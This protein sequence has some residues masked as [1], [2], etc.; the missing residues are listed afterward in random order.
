MLMRAVTTEAFRT[1]AIETQ[2][3][4][5]CRET[6]PDNSI[7]KALGIVFSAPL[8]CS[9]SVDMVNAQELPLGF[10]AA[11]AAVTIMIIN[12][13][14]QLVGFAFRIGSLFQVALLAINCP[15][16][17]AEAARTFCQRHKTDTP[18]L[19]VDGSLAESSWGAR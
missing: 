3:L 7:V 9:I 6:P 11:S 15:V 5:V 17:W 19:H 10:P 4:E 1:V 18:A 13:A 16:R 2:E 12:K 14:S 8:T